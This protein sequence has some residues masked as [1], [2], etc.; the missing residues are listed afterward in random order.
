MNYLIIQGYKDAAEKFSKETCVA[1]EMDLN[2]ITDRMTIR[3]AIEAGQID[4]AI[5]KVNDLDPEVVKLPL[6]KL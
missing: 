1:P 4:E 6:Q 5:E 3:K 2:S